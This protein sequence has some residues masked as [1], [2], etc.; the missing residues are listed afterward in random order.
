MI[1]MSGKLIQRWKMGAGGFIG[2]VSLFALAESDQYVRGRGDDRMYVELSNFYVHPLR[3]GRG[4]GRELLT[5]AIAYA[6][7]SG[8]VIFLRVVPY[9][10]SPSSVDELL[11]LYRQHGFKCTRCDPR[12][13]LLK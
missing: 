6:Q 1:H 8:W 7:G 10:R 2:E 11:V 12:E 13:M 3:R 9:G 4:W 5:T